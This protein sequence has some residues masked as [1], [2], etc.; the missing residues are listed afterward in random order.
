MWITYTN[1]VTQVPRLRR[2]IEGSWKWRGH[3]V[4]S[5]ARAERGGKECWKAG[6]VRETYIYV[7]TYRDTGVNWIRQIWN[8]WQRHPGGLAVNRI[9]IVESS[10]VTECVRSARAATLA[11]EIIQ[12]FPATYSRELFR[13]LPHVRRRPTCVSWTRCSPVRQRIDAVTCV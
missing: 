3:I 4:D 9:A 13:S 5:A 11:K 6:A 1:W 12:A 10:R 7:R 2:R 8:R